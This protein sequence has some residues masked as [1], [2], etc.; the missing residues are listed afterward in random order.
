MTA[1]S[2]TGEKLSMF[3]LGKSKTLRAFKNVKQMSCRCRNQQKVRISGEH[4][5]RWVGPLEPL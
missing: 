1:A 3:V 5:K 2:A 4:F